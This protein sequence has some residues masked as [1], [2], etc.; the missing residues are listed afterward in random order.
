[1]NLTTWWP[2]AEAN[3]LLNPAGPRPHSCGTLR[4]SPQTAL[5][6]LRSSDSRLTSRFTKGRREVSAA[7]PAVIVIIDRQIKLASVR[8]LNL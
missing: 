1:V 3:L 6:A 5:A 7:V 2:K 4:I 8:T